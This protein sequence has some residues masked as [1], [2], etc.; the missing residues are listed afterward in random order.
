MLSM[1]VRAVSGY[2]GVLGTLAVK[3]ATLPFVCQVCFRH[4]GTDVRLRVHYQSDHARGS[5][6]SKRPRK[7]TS[8]ALQT[9]AVD[10]GR[11]QKRLR[12]L[13]ARP[14]SMR[15]PTSVQGDIARA[16][17]NVDLVIKIAD[18]ALTD[19]GL[20]ALMRDMDVYESFLL[21]DEHFLPDK[22]VKALGTD[23]GDDSSSEL[24]VGSSRHSSPPQNEQ[25]SDS[26]AVSVTHLSIFTREP[27]ASGL[28]RVGKV[29]GSAAVAGDAQ[30]DDDDWILS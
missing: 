26:E 17:Y 20:S 9:A 15:M 5:K 12:P 7:D 8:D 28:G 30:C 16:R 6:G 3:Q 4:F 10:E 19:S 23:D 22:Q 14:S 21:G 24:A 18:A 11:S 25:Q 27:Q 13:P 2:L 1:P 29:D